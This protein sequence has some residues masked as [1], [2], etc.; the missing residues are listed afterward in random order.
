MVSL[1]TLKGK[2]WSGY[3]LAFI[4]LLVSYFLIFYTMQR[5]VQET[6]SVAHTYNVINRLEVLRGQVTQAETG[7]RGYVITK[8][9]RFRTPYNEAII[10]IPVIYQ[11]LKEL[12]KDSPGQQARLDILMRL[13]EERLE[14]LARGLKAFEANELVMPDS[15]RANRE[16]S[17]RIMDSIQVFSSHLKS[18]EEKLMELRKEKLTGFFDSTQLIAMISLAIAFITLFYSLIIFNKENKAK[19]KA[20]EKAMQYSVELENNISKLKAT[21]LELEEF[22]SLEKFTATGRIARTIAHEVRNPLTNISLATEQLV[23]NLPPTKESAVLLDMISRNASR[24]N[25][26]VSELLNA[27]RFANLEFRETNVTHLVEETLEL[28]KDRI[29]LNHVQVEKHYSPEAIQVSV[30]GEKM[31]LALLNIIVNAIEAME[32]NEGLLIIKT[33][34]QGSKCIIEIRDNGKGMDEEV[35]KNLFEPYF[36][37]KLKGNGLGLTNTQNVIFNHKGTIKVYSKPGQGATFIIALNIETENEP[38]SIPQI[39]ENNPH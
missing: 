2:V 24:I 6:N 35:L 39:G 28:A 27:T 15:M 4:L 30:D 16:P 12:I 22:K 25:Q 17:K 19:E 32:K 14:Y 13:I 37:G 8:D 38:V 20:M 26:L 3:F 7:V 18:E 9:L 29:E 31:K 11:E 10:S 34:R 21:N 1:L 36:T 5:S 23:E 33:K